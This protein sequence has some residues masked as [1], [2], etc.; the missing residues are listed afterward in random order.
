M[1]IR[2]FRP[3]LL[4]RVGYEGIDRI[5]CLSYKKKKIL[6]MM[7]YSIQKAIRNYL[8]RKVRMAKEGWSVPSEEEVNHEIVSIR[9]R[10]CIQQWDGKHF[11]CECK[12]LGIITSEAIY[13]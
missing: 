8:R 13:Y 2:I 7:E 6:W 5:A 3:Y 4:I 10:F 9:D 11:N 12:K 1:K